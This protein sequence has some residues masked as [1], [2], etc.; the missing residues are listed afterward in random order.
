[1]A[2]IDITHSERVSV[3]SELALE[4]SRSDFIVLPR[5]GAAAQVDSRSLC[6][7]SN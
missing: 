5:A 6:M 1:M 4:P 2:H 3:V 7:S